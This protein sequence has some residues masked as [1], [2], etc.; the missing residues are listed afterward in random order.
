MYVRKRSL[1]CSTVTNSPCPEA[2]KRHPP[3][4]CGQ[5]EA[6]TYDVLNL[7]IDADNPNTDISVNI[8][9]RSTLSPNKEPLYF[10]AFYG[11]AQPFERQ[12]D[13][14]TLCYLFKIFVFL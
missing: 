6:L 9:F 4:L 8:S 7:D 10:V 5:V 2:P 11:N 13:V 3:P 14:I 12:I 1:D